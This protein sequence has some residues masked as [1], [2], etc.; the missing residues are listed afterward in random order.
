MFDLVRPITRRNDRVWMDP[1]KEM[2]EFRRNFFG[3]PF[4][5]G[6]DIAEFKT[7]ISDEG[8]RYLLESDLPGFSKEDIKLDI[9]GDILTINAERKYEGEEKDEKGRYIRRERSF[10]S[11]S[12][13]FDISGIK[14][15]DI[16][17]K[18]ENGV[19]KLSLPKK[20]PSVPESRRLTIE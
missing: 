9:N 16:T 20:Q 10:G 4:F 18:Y 15:E 13:A 3:D 12:R 19:L 14:S 7:D 8:D 11:Y 17:A 1:F 2:E 6:R 5:S